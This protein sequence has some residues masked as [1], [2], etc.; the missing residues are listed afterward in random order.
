MGKVVRDFSSVLPA[1]RVYVFD[2]G[3]TDRTSAL[4]T[5]AGAIVVPSLIPGKGH[6]VKHMFDVVDADIYLMVDGDDTY[7]AEYAQQLVGEI[8]SGK[9]S[10]VVGMRLSDFSGRSFRPFHQFGNRLVSGLTSSI[11]P[12]AI[13]DVMSGYR[14]FS[15][16]FIKTIPIHSGGFEIE[17]E[18]TLQ[19]LSKGFRIKEIPIRYGERPEG[20]HSKLN[21][22]S[23]GLLV[24]RSIFMIMKDYRPLLFF[25][26]L[27]ALFVGLSLAAAWLPVADYLRVH[28]VFHVPLAVLSAA[29]GILSVLFFGIGLILDTVAK[30]HL[31]NFEHWR[32]H[33]KL[34][35]PKA[36][37]EQ[38][39]H[40]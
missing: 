3:S 14:A 23:D 28:Y 1:S 2:N 40:D 30:Y 38:E 16:E 8:Q 25:S 20:S 13:S 11:F 9:Y 18:M 22:Y 10:M 15:R 21:T 19:A 27:G 36:S 12:S 4:A 5:E 33:F 32:R 39:K 35:V 26:I 6:V 17:T 29:L 34:Q 31:E 7:P 37:T 24:L